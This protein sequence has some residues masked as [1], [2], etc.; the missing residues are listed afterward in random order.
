MRLAAA[1]PFFLLL[2]LLLLLSPSTSLEPNDLPFLVISYPDHFQCVTGNASLKVKVDLMLPASI[3]AGSFAQGE[4]AESELCFQVHSGHQQFLKGGGGGGGG[5]ADGGRIVGPVRCQPL[6]T[7]A[8]PTF[9]DLAP[10]CHTL[11]AWWRYSSALVGSAHHVLFR[12]AGSGGIAGSRKVL[13]PSK[14]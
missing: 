10:G 7:R 4:Y 13:R 3:D 6:S 2:L 11:L 9:S 5:G 1:V 12:V 8:P 14:S